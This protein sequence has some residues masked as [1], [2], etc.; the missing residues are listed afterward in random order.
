MKNMISFKFNKNRHLVL[1]IIGQELYPE[2]EY[3]RKMFPDLLPVLF[4]R[5]MQEVKSQPDLHDLYQEP[6][7]ETGIRQ[8][9]H[10]LLNFKT[11]LAT[12]PQTVVL[13][14]RN[15]IKK[16]IR[17]KHSTRDEW[18]D[19]FQEVIARLISGKIH[20]IQEK[21]DFSF[22]SHETNENTD[23]Q[24]FVKKP[25][26]SSYLMVSVRNIYMDIIR[27]RNVRP[28]TRG[29]VLSIDD[30]L[31][32]YEEDNMLE[33]LVIEE[34][35][36][37]FHTVLNLYYHSRSKLELCLKLKC[38][39]PLSREDILLCFPACA[40]GDIDILSHDYKGI[41][42][43]K[44][45]DLVVPA[46][47]RNEERENKSDTLRKWISI[48]IDEMVSHM[49]QTHYYPVYTSKNFVDFITLYYERSQEECQWA[50]NTHPIETGARVPGNL[51][52]KNVK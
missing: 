26:F 25:S 18:E 21:F 3:S 12:S 33:R 17:Y 48:K 41:K 7:N 9:V 42:D 1:D 35:C 46:F 24:Q 49:N 30:V 8:Q 32:I 23:N 31:E 39:I 36:Q 13:L 5:F 20:R 28:L 29:N 37:K 2:E 44:V 22:A 14:Y 11:L 40:P 34:E 50:E 19:I 45:F 38:R 15:C 52:I 51:T 27:E 6:G 10:D 47:N 4:E 43:K 16:F